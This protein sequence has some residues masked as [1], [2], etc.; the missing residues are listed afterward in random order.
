MSARVLSTFHVV[1]H[2]DWADADVIDWTRYGGG[3]SLRALRRDARPYDVVVLDGSVGF[4]QR[5]RDVVCARA[6]IA[7]PSGPAVV[8]TDSTWEP[9]SRA[10]ARRLGREEPVLRRAS[11]VVVRGFDTPR[12]NFCV[13]SRAETESFPRSWGL[14]RAHVHPTLFFHTLREHQLTPVSDGGYVFA[15][16]TPLRDHQLLVEASRGQS[17]RTVIATEAELS[18]LPDNVEAGLV[19]RE[20]YLELLRG[21]G[22]TVVEAMLRYSEFQSADEIFSTGNYRKVSPITRIDERILQPDPVDRK[23]R[24]LYWEVAHATVA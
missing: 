11:Q 12:M 22:V 20:R 13:L 18:A 8:L 4:Q 9:G 19:A 6:L 23:A 5:Y 2:P 14:R 17:W 1:G 15:G 16:G 10:I 3:R 21:A 7:G 24:E